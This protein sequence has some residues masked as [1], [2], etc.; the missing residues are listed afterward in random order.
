MIFVNFNLNTNRKEYEQI[1]SKTSLKINRLGILNQ[2]DLIIKIYFKIFVT[3][4]Q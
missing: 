1:E 3:D 4:S 2:T